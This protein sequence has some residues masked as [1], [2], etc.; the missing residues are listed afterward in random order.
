MNVHENKQIHLNFK[1]E[2]LD[3]FDA[4]IMYETNKPGLPVFKNHLTQI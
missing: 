3:A 2:F 4:N 1:I